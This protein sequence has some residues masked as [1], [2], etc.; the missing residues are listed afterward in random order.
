MVKPGRFFV[1]LCGKN[2]LKTNRK[3]YLPDTFSKYFPNNVS[4][5]WSQVRMF[6]QNSAVLI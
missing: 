5:D 4:L 6:G 1:E 2:A 3:E